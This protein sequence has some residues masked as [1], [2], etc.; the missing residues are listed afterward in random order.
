MVQDMKQSLREDDFE[1]WMA[2]IYIHAD[3]EE[4]GKT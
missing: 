4:E 1:R 2:Y 3:T